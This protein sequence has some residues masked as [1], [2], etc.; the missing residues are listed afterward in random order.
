MLYIHIESIDM[1]T[2]SLVLYKKPPGIDT[3]MM[4]IVNSALYELG[5]QQYE[6]E[7]LLA[8]Q[9]STTGNKTVQKNAS[10][11]EKYARDFFDIHKSDTDI[12]GLFTLIGGRTLVGADPII[13]RYIG[14]YIDITKQV[15]SMTNDLVIISNFINIIKTDVLTKYITD[16]ESVWI[17]R[18]DIGSRSINNVKKALI[19][20]LKEEIK[21][22]FIDFTKL[23]NN[24]LEN[25]KELVQKKISPTSGYKSP[26]KIKTLA[27]NAYK[28]VEKKVVDNDITKEAKLEQIYGRLSALQNNLY[29]KL[30]NSFKKLLAFYIIFNIIDTRYYD[31]LDF[32]YDTK[33]FTN[34][35]SDK[36]QGKVNEIVVGIPLLNEKA[37]ESLKKIMQTYKYAN[38]KK[39][40]SP[41]F[42]TSRESFLTD[43][44]EFFEYIITSLNV[45]PKTMTYVNT[46]RKEI[47]DM[48]NSTITTSGGASTRR[49]SI[50][51]QRHRKDSHRTSRR[52]NRQSNKRRTKSQRR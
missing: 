22:D 38:K 19:E 36:F 3:E 28:S 11:M 46:K 17:Q 14:F 37:K 15:G 9:C 32:E 34:N 41:D 27:Y 49:K 20:T 23:S 25:Y 39:F 7:S 45:I 13:L 10:E 24:Y 50:R 21:S 18:G 1:D 8:Q 16:Y 52:V 51:I 47:E 48:M 31:R 26:S 29:F 42:R 6:V 40:E 12:S 30:M 43:L 35:V 33:T 2:N 4:N 44:I 5:Y